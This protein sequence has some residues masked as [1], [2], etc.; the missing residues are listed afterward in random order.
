MQILASVEPGTE[1]SLSYRNLL[2]CFCA[3][4]CVESWKWV[5]ESQLLK[6][7]QCGEDKDAVYVPPFC[8]GVLFL[9][10]S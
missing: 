6:A 5:T 2:F 8:T 4:G 3:G 10:K 1:G 9:N 7:P